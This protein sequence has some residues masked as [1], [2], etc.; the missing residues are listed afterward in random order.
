MNPVLILTHNNLELTKRCV[1]SIRKQDVPTQIFII[2][3]GSKDGTW[4][5]ADKEGILLI[6]WQENFGVSAGWNRGLNHIFRNLMEDWC[7][8]IGN[9]TILPPWGY[10]LLQSYMR[11]FVTGVAV[12][13][14]M[15]IAEP[16]TVRGMEKHPDFSCFLIHRYTWDEIG[17]FDE[18]MKHYCSDCDFHVRAHRMGVT[19]WK[20]LVPYFHERSSTIR[21]ATPEDRNAIES[22]ANQDRAVFRE[23]YGCLPGQSAYEEMFK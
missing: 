13:S 1:D 12:D 19:L 16:P 23:L 21:L 20:V 18:R 3:N 7:L 4:E 22:Q 8:C 6:A 11:G 10:R 9:D 5:W 17:K 15:Q 14:M 2:D